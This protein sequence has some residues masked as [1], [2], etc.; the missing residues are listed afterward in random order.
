MCLMKKTHRGNEDDALTVTPLG[1][2]PTA[3]LLNALN[4]L[5]GLTGFVERPA[6]RPYAFIFHLQFLP[7]RMLLTGKFTE[8]AQ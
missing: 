6:G 1:F 4:D 3:H 7:K 2:G 8:R 5:H